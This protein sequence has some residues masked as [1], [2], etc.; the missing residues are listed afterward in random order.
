MKAEEE[1]VDKLMCHSGVKEIDHNGIVIR[2]EM[3]VKKC[4]YPADGY[5][6]SSRCMLTE[7]ITRT[8][9][10]PGKSFHYFITVHIV[11]ICMN[12]GTAY[13]VRLHYIRV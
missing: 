11:S 1:N 4:N 12:T 9:N 13:W 7:V 2:D 3:E 5:P 10:E 8:K 6:L